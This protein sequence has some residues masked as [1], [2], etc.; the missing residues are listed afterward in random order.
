MANQKLLSS[1]A[2]TMSFARRT[3]TANPKQLSAAARANEPRAEDACR[4]PAAILETTLLLRSD[5]ENPRRSP[6]A[7]VLK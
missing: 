6:P 1:A 4:R 2:R 5:D 3:Q 7:Q